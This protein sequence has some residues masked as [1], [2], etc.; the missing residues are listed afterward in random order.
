M[1]FDI[2]YFVSML[3]IVSIAVWLAIRVKRHPEKDFLMRGVMKEQKGTEYEKRMQKYFIFCY[4]YGCVYWL[5]L[6][7]F[8][9]FHNL[10][11]I[12]V[13]LTLLLAYGLIW[14][15]VRWRC[16]G[17]YNKWVFIVLATLV[18]LGIGYQIWAYQSSK[19]E[20][21]PDKLS[22]EG[23]Y[24]IA[25]PYQSID[26]VFILNE[27]PETEYCI[28]GHNLFCGKKGKYHMEKGPD[29]RFYVLR[30]EAPYLMMYTDSGLILVNR[31]TPAKTE[32]LIEELKDKIG[33]KMKG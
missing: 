26:S 33:D 6:F 7:E 12:I 18:S 25:I 23:N 29:V 4:L 19:V 28:K 24:S 32:Q 13:E 17:K 5:W 11:E 9:W 14:Y 21:L 15:I 22:I 2:L 20:V 1:I 27:L 16:T 10:F 3:L 30:K 31:K 8:Y